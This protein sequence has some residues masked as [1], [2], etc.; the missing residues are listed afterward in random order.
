VNDFNDAW[1]A[2]YGETP[3]VGWR[4]RERFS[5][6]WFRIHGLPEMKQYP[7]TPDELA[8]IHHRHETL[9]A[10]LF[11]MD[12]GDC[13][14]VIPT[15]KQ[16]IGT[17][18]EIEWSSNMEFPIG[19]R[20]DKPTDEEDPKAA[21][22]ASAK[23]SALG[24]RAA[25]ERIMKNETRILWVSRETREVFAP[26]DGGVDIIAADGARMADLARR[27]KTWRSPRPDG[28]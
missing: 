2:R 5:S 1:R 8:E 17:P 21:W 24:T 19:W 20:P 14:I 4:L 11:A 18:P 6:R 25:R 26:Y 28:L 23:W 7:E 16:E 27:F 10:E 13:W 15:W 12:D 22:V 3:P 9:A